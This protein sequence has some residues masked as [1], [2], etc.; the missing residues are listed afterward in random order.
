[1][2]VV[3]LDFDGVV[4]TPIWKRDDNYELHCEYNHPRDGYL[5]NFQA[6][7]WV[8]EFCEK[9][10]YHIVVTS[11]WRRFV[12]DLQELL[13]DSGLREGIKVIDRTEYYVG[14]S[15]GSEISDWLTKHP[16]VENYLIF[17]DEDDMDEH[18]FRLVKCNKMVGFTGD[19][20]TQ[21][22]SLHEAFKK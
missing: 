20:F 18:E 8:S 11:T 16:E 4:N 13:D 1:M 6:I 3:F 10:N 21:A 17:D 15:R 19:S 2:N 5:N 22:V 12:E 9:Y 7:Q 14:C